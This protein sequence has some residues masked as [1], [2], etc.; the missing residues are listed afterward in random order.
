MVKIV[1][2]GCMALRTH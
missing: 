1:Q 2:V